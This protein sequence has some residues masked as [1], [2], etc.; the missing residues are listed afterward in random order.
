MTEQVAEAFTPVRRQA[1]SDAV[2]EQLR[3]RIVNGDLAAGAPLPAERI[4]CEALGV[5]RSSV[6]EALRRLEQARLI[7]VRHGGTSHILDYR[8]SA[9]LDL[10]AALLVN[11]G[12]FDARVVRGVME[13][14]SAIAAD[15][16]R[17][18]A[19]RADATVADRLDSV[20]HAMSEAG[21][22]LVRL[23]SLAVSFW[24]A[25]IDA[26]DNIA[27][28]LAYNSLRET[29]DQCRALLVEALAG[30]LRD[31]PRY[32]AIADGVR[33]GDAAAAE[34]LARE[35]AR[36]G[37]ESIGRILRRLDTASTVDGGIR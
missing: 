11:A 10:L 7:S 22:D 8:E 30:E 19:T 15:A 21:G 31:V 2:F 35:L 28:R 12:G 14:R 29:Y 34:H 24:S 36:R 3:A 18:A 13:M 33:R 32:A 26:S 25:I 20:V 37:E 17:L 4:L 9:G 16:A 1:L 5:N 6:R 23:Q 27:Y